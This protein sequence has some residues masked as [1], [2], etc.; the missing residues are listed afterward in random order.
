V[1]KS[2]NS[3]RD[4]EYYACELPNFEHKFFAGPP[5]KKLANLSEQELNQLVEQRHLALRDEPNKQQTGLYQPFEV[6]NALQKF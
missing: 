3:S 5:T 6:S 1:E 2:T 4:E